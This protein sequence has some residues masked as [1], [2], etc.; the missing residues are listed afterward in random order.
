MATELTVKERAFAQLIIEGTKTAAYRKVY[1]DRGSPATTAVAAYKLSRKPKIK[2]E[3]ARLLRQREFP[4]DDYARIRDVAVAGLTEIFLQESDPRLRAKVGSVLL[5]YA[6]AGLKL[7][8]VPTEKERK[9][10]EFN[11]LLAEVAS[12]RQG[13]LS[14]EQEPPIVEVEQTDLL[15][16]ESLEEV[17]EGE[18]L[19]VPDASM[20]EITAATEV[21]MDAGSGLAT[22]EAAAAA[23]IAGPATENGL[24]PEGVQGGSIDGSDCSAI[25]SPIPR[26]YQQASWPRPGFR[27]EMIRGRFPP[28]FRWVPDLEGDEA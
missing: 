1:S 12:E 2:N 28:Q 21:L 23:P 4:A 22:Q 3:V 10:D 24:V 9:Y 11:R 14:R 16:A 17:S 18:A 8:P 6:D 13:V 26:A 15:P 20:C 19:E 27:R 7:H 25:L 5:A